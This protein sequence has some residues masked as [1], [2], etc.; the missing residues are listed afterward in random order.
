MTQTTKAQV[1]LAPSLEPIRANNKTVFLAGSTN[2][3][4]AKDELDWRAFITD[5]LADI[6]DLTIINPYRPDWDNWRE[7]ETF[8]PFVEQVNWELD[9]LD[10]ADLIVV[11]FHP[12]TVAS[13]SMLEF[14]L[15][16]RGSSK[17]IPQQH[18]ICCPDGYF[19]KGNVAIVCKRLGIELVESDDEL[20]DAIVEKLCLADVDSSS[21]VNSLYT[22]G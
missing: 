18:I 3:D 22:R 12:D 16:A 19:K 21:D 9:M 8:D 17:N 2:N 4:D 5:S 1:I 20:R 15:N 10:C 6:P 14:G 11:Y 7:D 13:I